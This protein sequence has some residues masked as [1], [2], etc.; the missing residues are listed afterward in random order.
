[1]RRQTRRTS[2]DKSIN[3]LFPNREAWD[4]FRRT[5]AYKATLE[6]LRTLENN[7]FTI[8]LW[9]HVGKKFFEN[10]F[11]DP[12]EDERKKFNRDL[13]S[14]LGRATWRFWAY[15]YLLYE[16]LLSEEAIIQKKAAK[17]DPE[18]YKYYEADYR[19]AMRVLLRLHK[20]GY[21]IFPYPFFLTQKKP[22]ISS[23]LKGTLRKKQRN[24]FFY[25]MVG[26]PLHGLSQYEAA[27]LLEDFFCAYPSDIIG[28]ADGI[29]DSIKKAA[30]RPPF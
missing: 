23:S 28:N 29:S 22:V 2:V 27:D 7:E 19:K 12:G 10:R 14:L 21:I 15:A 4:R 25:F 3:D 11:P 26:I 5:Q 13:E 30:Q 24:V 8:E 1:M 6:G 17:E 20:K 18:N 9:G 16:S